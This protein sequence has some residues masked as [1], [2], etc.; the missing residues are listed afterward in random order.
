M[1]VPAEVFSAL[2]WGA[3]G[4]VALAAVYLLVVL[5]R[6]WLAGELW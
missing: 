1:M 6:E 4:V 3:L 2:L 5:V